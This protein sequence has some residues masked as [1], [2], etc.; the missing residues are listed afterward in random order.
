MSDFLTAIIGCLPLMLMV[1]LIA[2][3]VS[4][5]NAILLPKNRLLR[6]FLGGIMRFVFVEP[7]RQSYRAIRWLGITTLTTNPNYRT[8]QLYLDN[9]PVTPLELYAEVEAAFDARQIVGV[10]LSRVS[11]LEWHLLSSRRIY[12]LA[13]FREAVCFIGAVPFGDGLLVSW[14]YSIWPGRSWMVVFQ[15]PYLGVLAERV[16]SQPT[17]HRGDV[18]YALEQAI[19]VCVTG[20]MDTLA[21]RGIRPLAQNEQPLLLREFY[22]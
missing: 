4:R 6:R 8:H 14:R 13:R 3:G 10:E 20:A 15:V 11:R 9:Y 19:R 2:F 12:L 22:E 16:F 7:V 17:F 18:Y 5:L 21:D 1:V